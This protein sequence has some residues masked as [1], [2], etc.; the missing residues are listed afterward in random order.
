MAS[1]LEDGRYTGGAF[2]LA[3]DRAGFM[4]RIIERVA[5]F[6][7]RLT[8]VPYGDQAIFI[9]REPFMEIGG[10]REIPLMEDM[11]LMRRIKQAGGKI[12]IIHKRAKTSGRRWLKEGVVRCTLR[13]WTI[14]LL[15]LA[16][17]DPN[18]L[19]KWYA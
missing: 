10:Y 6:R 11:D 13:N 9:K 17:V 1:T 3:I 16:G 18:R 7:S 19:V 12:C 15:Y 5:S 2:D 14:R 8:R 4:F